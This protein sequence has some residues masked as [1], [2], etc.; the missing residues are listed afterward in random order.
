MPVTG[1]CREGGDLAKGGA[2]KLC[3]RLSLSLLKDKSRFVVSQLIKP[4]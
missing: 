3:V 4:G 1:K 2:C